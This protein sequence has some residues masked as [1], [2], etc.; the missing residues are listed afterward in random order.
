MTQP[1]KCP[2]SNDP[3]NGRTPDLRRSGGFPWVWLGTP[4][5]NRPRARIMRYFTYP[6]G[7]TQFRVS[8]NPWSGCF[9]GVGYCTYT[10]D[11]CN[12]R[13]LPAGP[14]SNG[15][16]VHAAGL[17]QTPERVATGHSKF[18]CGKS[19]PLC[20]TRTQPTIH[21]FYIVI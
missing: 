15:T 7:F 17:V 4:N 19:G 1:G 8:R 12:T 20:G 13:M 21:N 9:G 11:T 10:P 2:A 14:D 3:Q 18:R 16:A 6:A 5:P